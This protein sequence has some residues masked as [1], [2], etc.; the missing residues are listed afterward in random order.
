M[1][2]KEAVAVLGIIFIRLLGVQGYELFSFIDANTHM[3][4]LTTSNMISVQSTIVTM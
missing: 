3:S 2:L 1:I 4:R